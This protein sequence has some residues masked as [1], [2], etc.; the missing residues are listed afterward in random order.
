MLWDGPLP[1]WLEEEDWF[2]LRSLW[3]PP[4][5]AVVGMMCE[6]GAWGCL[7]VARLELNLAV[8]GGGRVEFC[9]VVQE[10]VRYGGRASCGGLGVGRSGGKMRGVS[11]K[12]DWSF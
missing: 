5:R 11:S 4:G 7:G 6:V 8:L 3:Y 1:C 12:V 10:V 2:V 9:A